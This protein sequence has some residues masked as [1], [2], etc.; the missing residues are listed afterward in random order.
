[1]NPLQQKR[2]SCR[3]R[4]LLLISLSQSLLNSLLYFVCIFGVLI[5]NSHQNPILKIQSLPHLQHLCNFWYLIKNYRRLNSWRRS[6]KSRKIFTSISYH[7]YSFCLQ[8]LQCPRNVQNVF[9]TSRDHI[10]WSPS[11]FPQISTYIHSLFITSMNSS[12]PSSNK[13]VYTSKSTTDHSS[14][15]C[16]RSKSFLCK[17]IRNISP[18]NLSSLWSISCK[19][20]NFIMRQSYMYIPMH[21][22]NRSRFYSSFPDDVFDLNCTNSVVW[23]WHSMRDDGRLKWHNRSIFF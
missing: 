12:Q 14:G 21:N 17:N 7:W 4:Y 22:G 11:Q 2:C 20:L 3:S 1:M 15:N 18:T 13:N 9:D 5:R 6:K 10:D 19:F 8:I 23:V 16:S